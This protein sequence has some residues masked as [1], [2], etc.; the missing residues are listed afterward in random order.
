GR[1]NANVASRAR[2]FIG[3][4]LEQDGSFPQAASAVG[5]RRGEGSLGEAAAPGNSG[6]AP[7][8]VLVAAAL[9]PGHT[10]D[11]D[12]REARPLGFSMRR[13]FYIVTA[14]VAGGLFLAAVLSYFVGIHQGSAVLRLS[15]WD[16]S[17]TLRLGL[18]D[19]IVRVVRYDHLKPDP[20]DQQP[21]AAP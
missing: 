13:V 9:R 20:P 7:D 1:R 11:G 18:S 4:V 15:D 12:W 19:A 5:A 3:R 10:G 8:G 2:R 16:G 6:Q 21:T 17:P 14:V